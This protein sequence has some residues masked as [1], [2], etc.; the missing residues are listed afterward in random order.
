MK[1]GI[2]LSI[3]F[4]TILIISIVIFALGMLIVRFFI[5]TAEDLEEEIS[6]STQRQVNQLLASSN[7]KVVL[8]EFRKQLKQG[9]RYSFA[10]GMKNYLE[11]KANFTVEMQFS[12]AMITEDE[13]LY[14]PASDM[15]KWIFESLGPFSLDDNEQL[16]ISLPVQTVAAE[17]GISYVFDVT[18]TCNQSIQLCNP[19]GYEQKIYI[20]IIK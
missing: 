7:E 3:N 18:V 10:L 13:S 1:K 19:Y 15:G 14:S 11:Q 12:H 16:V 8:P 2:T 4:I 9:Q 17:I 20:D 6:V 5:G